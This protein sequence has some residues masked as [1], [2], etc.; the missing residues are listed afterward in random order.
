MLSEWGCHD[1][2]LGPQSWPSGLLGELTG[3]HGG[4]FGAMDPPGRDQFAPC[5][6]TH[7]ADGERTADEDVALFESICDGLESKRRLS[8]DLLDRGGWDLFLNVMGESHCVG[9]QLW[10]LHDRAHPKHDPELLR[11][12]GGDPVIEVYRRLD[13]VLADHMERLGPDD[14]IYMMFPHG[15]A[16]HHDGTHL[17]DHVLH[18]LD[19]S[20]DAPGGHGRGTRAAAELARLVPQPVRGPALR[21]GAPL[22]RTRAGSP[23]P[24]PL[25]PLEQRR[26]FQA[27]NNTVVGAVRL[28]LAG[29]EPAGRIHPDDR[30]DV[31][32]WLSRRL[33]ELVNV[34]TGGRVVRSCRITDDVFART[35]GD[36]FPDLFVEWERSAPIERVWSPAAGTV[37]IPYEHWRQG[38]HVREGLVFAAGPGIRPGRRREVVDTVHLGATI[39]AALGAPLEDADGRPVESVLP[40]GTRTTGGRA[41]RRARLEDALRR[42]A[43]ARVP[44]WA[45]RQDPALVRTRLE[46]AGRAGALEASAALA[47]SELAALR[48][49]VSRLDRHG[50]IAAMSAWLPQADVP[51]ELLISVVLPTRDRR[52]LLATAI[53]SVEAQSYARWE[54]LVVDDGSSDG[55]AEFLREIEDPRVRVLEK[56]GGLGPCGARNLA[57]DAASGDVIV[58]LDDDNRQT[59][60]GS[61]P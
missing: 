43:E 60:T 30:R 27:P 51:E 11:R 56:G 47:H 1:R 23:P 4:H 46:L 34:E 5:D 59:A 12:I 49:Q 13:A 41:R 48:S 7:R 42:R 3:R 40:E 50:D 16:A 57:L 33:E 55:T 18:R 61:G 17:L 9:H 20:L 22:L 32:R 14:T 15:M 28:N 31:L 54:L 53:E 2:H 24:E 8:L 44:G 35:P 6:Y 45:G 29:R 37:A 10:H 26:W 39:C 36:A 58:Y 19:W 25:P 52:R 21:A 38:D